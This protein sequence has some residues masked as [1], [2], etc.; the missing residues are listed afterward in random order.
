MVWYVIVGALALIGCRLAFNAGRYG[1]AGAAKRLDLSVLSIIFITLILVGDK[2]FG[3]K[4][5]FTGIAIVLGVSLFGAWMGWGLAN[6]PPSQSDLPTLLAQL[7][8][9]RIAVLSAAVGRCRSAAEVLQNYLNQGG[10]PAGDLGDSQYVVWLKESP[11]GSNEDGY[12]IS[13]PDTS[14]QLRIPDIKKE[15]VPYPL[16]NENDKVQEFARVVIRDLVEYVH[17]YEQAS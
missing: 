17:R 2:V 11:T 8:D 10:I 5:G 7:K 6:R 15:Y 13:T 14:S 9:R 3:F 1:M 16:L 12:L 4:I